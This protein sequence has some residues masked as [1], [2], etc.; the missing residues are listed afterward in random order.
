[1][2]TQAAS[3]KGLGPSGGRLL[4]FGGSG[5]I[6]GAIQETFEARGWKV[7][8]TSRAPDAAQMKKGFIAYDPRTSDPSVLD[9][10]ALYQ[11]VC[12]AQG[13]NT[14]DSF[15][16]VDVKKHMALYEANC[17]FI[18]ASLNSLLT[19]GLLAKPARLCVISSIWQNM[20]RQNKLSYTM[21]KAALQ[22]L[23]LSASVDLAADGH[24]VNAVLPG[25]LNTP[26]TRANL[27][28]EQ[29]EKVENATRFQRLPALHDVANIA[30]YLCS[31]ENTGITGQFI[32]A[33]LGFSHAR[34]I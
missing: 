14:N 3:A 32:S 4:L 9:A 2:N 33:D 1:M 31:P 16:D 19:R 29:I 21:T 30:Y 23:V 7:T 6:A 10:G 24:L 18:I 15:Y 26:M 27:K 8:S 22:G 20:A 13:A 28:A 17:L 5:A 25:V 34:I 12:W 11:A